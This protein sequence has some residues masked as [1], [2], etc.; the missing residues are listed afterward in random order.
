[1][2]AEK[3]SQKTSLKDEI[4]SYIQMLIFVVVVVS[5]VNGVLL[6]NAKIPSSSM[7]NTIMVNDRIFGNRLAYRSKD[8]ERFDIIIFKF[9]DD[10]SKKYIK[11][12]IGMPGETVLIVDGK[13]F[14]D[15]SSEPLPDSF[16]RKTRS[17]PSD[18]MRYRRAAILSWGITATIVMI[19]DS[20]RIHL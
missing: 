6:I 7:E 5:V 8:P 3:E 9:P 12:I 13:V 1:M 4:I 14:I 2:K 19:R 18:L 15:G 11:R 17:A 10:E 16:C 20:G